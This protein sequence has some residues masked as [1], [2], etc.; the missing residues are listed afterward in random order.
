MEGRDIW[1]NPATDKKDSEYQQ[2]EPRPHHR[3]YFEGGDLLIRVNNA[4]F[5]IHCDLIARRSV[6]MRDMFTL[7]S[8]AAQGQRTVEVTLQGDS[9]NAWERVMELLYPDN[10]FKPPSFSADHWADILLLAHKYVMEDISEGSLQQ[11]KAS[12]PP[13]NPIRMIKVALGVDSRELYQE[14]VNELA[15]SQDMMSLED[16]R[17]IGIEAFYDIC[18]LQLERERKLRTPINPF[19][20]GSPR[21][22]DPFSKQQIL[23]QPPRGY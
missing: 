9:V 8:S 19:L 3:F 17:L 4:I 5:K 18:S 22:Y 21:P 7:P 1:T 6:V 13:L 15:K 11:L 20:P 2:G 10:L 12:K 14:A 23:F 16:A